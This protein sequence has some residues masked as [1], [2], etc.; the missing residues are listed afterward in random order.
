MNELKIKVT[1]LRDPNIQ[2]TPQ[3]AEKEEGEWL[4]FVK[5]IMRW[6]KLI[7][8]FDASGEIGDNEDSEN[9]DFSGEGDEGANF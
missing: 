6:R 9:D 8:V 1:E 7:T 4:E 5:E 2:V 3:A